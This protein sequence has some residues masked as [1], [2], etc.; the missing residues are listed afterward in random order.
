M[1]KKLSLVLII[2]LLPFLAKAGTV[3]GKVTDNTGEPLPF[4]IVFV[5]GTTNGT[6]ANAN[7]EYQLHL[8]DG[9]YQLTV[10]YMGYKQ[11]SQL[12]TVKGNGTTMK[13]FKLLEQALELK[14]AVI[15][16]EDPAYYIIRKAIERRKFHL[17]QVRSFQTSIYLKGVLRNRSL[18]SDGT[19]KVIAG[20]SEKEIKDE[21]GMDS[22][23][24][25][26][27]Y[28]CEEEADYYSQGDKERTIIRSV[29]ESGNPNGLGF[30]QMPQVITFYEN[31][32]RIFSNLNP[33]GF[34][35]PISENALNYYR[36]TY[37]GEFKEGTYTINKIKVAPK[38]LYEPLYE[39]Y[40]YIV[41]DDWAIHSLNLHV[42]KKN[43]LDLLDTLK[44]E[45]S[46]LPLEKD[47]W[48]VKNQV[49]Y[50][51]LSIFGFN[52]TGHAVTIYNNQKVNQPIPDTVFD[53]KITSS[54]EKTANKK[55]SSYWTEN[56]P[57]PLEDDEIK[58]Y[59]I[60]DSLN[61]K[62]EDPAYQDSMRRRE[63]RISLMDLLVF[64]ESQ[65]TKHRKNTF[66]I[67]PILD[68]IP[69][70]S[71]MLSY[72][73]VEGINVSPGI[74]W[75]RTVDTGKTLAANVAGR[76]GFSN[77]HINGIGSL[78]Y[79]VN[80]REWRGKSWSIGG[81]GGS[82]VFQYNPANPIEPIY[83]VFST[84]FWR[85]NHMK[86]YE[87]V[88]GSLYFARNHGNGFRWKA[89]TSYQQRY[90]LFNSD[91][92][93]LAGK[94]VMPLSDNIPPQLKTVLWQNHKAVLFT[95][96]L[97][98]KPGYTYTLFPDQKVPNGSNWPVFILDYQKGLPGILNSDVNFDKWRFSIGD[99][100]RLKLLGSISYNIAAGGFLNKNAVGS[101]DMM[102]LNGNQIVLS[103]PYLRSFQLLPY[104][105]HS[106]TEIIYGE[107]HV[108]YSLKGLLTNKIPLLR[109]LQWYLMLGSNSFYVNKGNYYT[110][111]FASIDNIG[112][113]MIRL[114]RVDFVQSW[115]S[116]RGQSFGVRV[117]LS[118]TFFSRGNN[119]TRNTDW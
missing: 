63:N 51:T 18:K 111:V 94:E 27:I 84:I 107:A 98:Y 89:S 54:Y 25:A 74:S 113:K 8:P 43:S 9:S 45:Q 49:I 81:S 108:E 80:D 95:L 3:V 5:K 33:R 112:F 32:I 1:L 21:L 92:F 56:R 97:S 36:Y 96:S 65:T 37:Q 114:F 44:I 20:S 40:I 26:V 66:Y 38:R 48:V 67:N 105:T 117:G 109:Q 59:V 110:E 60:K 78:S 7:G 17:Q 24:K 14:E 90:I 55:D 57:I 2:V 30:S 72:N 116:Y 79:T 64:G 61:K 102:H 15:K 16:D 106:N 28:L 115:D 70:S 22:N 4:A 11:V 119:E 23:G 103:A 69:G 118:G 73:A 86:L 52:I 41:S 99:D 77:G 50:P 6:S 85:K 104:Y 39:G 76:Y 31:N 91:T 12:V 34:V 101:Q 93:S 13:N 47:V 42:T 53:N 75:R 46:F 19:L 71:G 82:Y 58:D 100:F 68:L 88:Q 10:Q 87:R 83:N 35:S 29:K 62:Y